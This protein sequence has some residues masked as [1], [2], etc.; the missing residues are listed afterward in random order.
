MDKKRKKE[1]DPNIYNLQVPIPRTLA[2]QLKVLAKADDRNLRTYCKKVLEAH[3]NGNGMSDIIKVQNVTEPT[4]M[5][6][7]MDE[8]QV[9]SEP[10][11]YEEKPQRPKVGKLTKK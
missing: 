8:T 2:E 3:V 6:V 4:E 7:T 10:S 1:T 5:A 9:N 11:K